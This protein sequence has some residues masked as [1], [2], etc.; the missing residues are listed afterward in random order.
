MHTFLLISL[1]D[2]AHR[3]AHEKLVKE[4]AD[5]YVAVQDTERRT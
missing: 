4:H 2:P 5:A 3:A 1:K